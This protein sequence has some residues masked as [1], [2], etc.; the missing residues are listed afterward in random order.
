MFEN[1]NFIGKTSNCC[2]AIVN[3]SDKCIV[4]FFVSLSI[5]GS[6][7]FLSIDIITLILSVVGLHV[8][9]KLVGDLL[10]NISLVKSIQLISSL[11]S[12]FPE[13]ALPTVL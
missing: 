8:V 9:E 1:F 12:A 10:R 2:S 7:D 5:D 6:L 13:I 4:I 3:I 11:D